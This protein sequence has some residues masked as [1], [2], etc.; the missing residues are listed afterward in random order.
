MAVNLHEGHREH[1]RQRFLRQM[2]D[3]FSD[4]ELLELLLFYA[5]PR[6]NTNELAHNLLRAFSSLPGV[7]DAPFEALCDKVTGIG[8]SAALLIKLVGTLINRY[9]STDTVSSVLVI[10]YPEDV[11]P[12]LQRL[13]FAKA[14]EI[15]YL[16]LF[17][18]AG[19]LITCTQ[20]G[21]GTASHMAV[22]MQECVRIASMHHAA[23]V[24]FSHNHPHGKA[25]PSKNDI[26]VTRAMK[27]AFDSV[28]IPLL[29]HVLMAENEYNLLVKYIPGFQ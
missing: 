27:Q 29:E 7:I 21:C 18:N 25:I 5:I 26:V 28:G 3:G 4:H 22:N 2:G 23:S 17:D 8:P 12:Y 13:Y 20:V 11:V 9:E 6:C 19:R 1:M 15:G 24:I 14:D 16:L 10:H